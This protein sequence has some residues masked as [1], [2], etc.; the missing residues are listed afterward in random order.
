MNTPDSPY[1]AVSQPSGMEADAGSAEGHEQNETPKGL[2]QK[3]PAAQSDIGDDET[4]TFAA[5]KAERRRTQSAAS[6]GPEWLGLALATIALAAAL[7]SAWL[8][9]IKFLSHY[10][11]DSTMFDS[12]GGTESDCA[13]AFSS[14]ASMLFGLPVTMYAMA[15]YVSLFVLGFLWMTLEARRPPSVTESARPSVTGLG[16]M[17]S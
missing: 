14:P 9:R 6:G 13:L 7:G 15:F 2:T 4:P 1:E 5:L 3:V 17:C 10:S 12:C 16:A 11:C 8:T